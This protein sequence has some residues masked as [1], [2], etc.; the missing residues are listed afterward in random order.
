MSDFY[1][2]KAWERARVLALKRHNY[3][4]VMSKRYGKNVPARAVH[5]ALPAKEY[6]QYRLAQWNLIPVCDKWHNKLEDRNNGTLTA[7]GEAL[8]RRVAIKN[9]VEY[10]NSKE[11]TGNKDCGKETGN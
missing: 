1:H 2:S 5:H 11:D 7:E 8:A 6:P 3:M 4:C 10:G 9:G